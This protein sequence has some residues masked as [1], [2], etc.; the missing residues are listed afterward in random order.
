MKT[1]MIKFWQKVLL[2]VADVV[3]VFFSA[4]LT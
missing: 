4:M 2:I 3:I 1:S